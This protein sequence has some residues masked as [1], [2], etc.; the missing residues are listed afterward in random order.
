MARKQ[1][2]VGI[3]IGHSNIRIVQVEKT[4][5]G[6]RLTKF[7]ITETPADSVR[8]G[9]VRNPE[10]VG[11]AIKTAMKEAH[12]NAH[13]AVIAASGGAVYVRAVPF[14]KMNAAMLRES[15]KFEASRYVPGSIEDSYVEAEIL[16]NLNDAQMN[17]LLAAAPRDIVDGRIAACKAAGLDVRVVEIETFAASRALLETDQTKEMGTNTYILVDIGAASTTV[18]VIENGT[19]VMHRSMPTAGNTLTEGLKAAFKLETVDAEAGKH[20]LDLAEFLTPEGQENPPLKVIAAHVD[21]LVRE[22]RRSMNYLQTQSQGDLTTPTKI[23]GMFL[24]GAGANLKGRDKYIQSKLGIP[25][26]TIGVF[27]NPIVTQTGV[28]SDTGVDLAVATGLAMRP[29]LHAA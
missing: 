14:P 11:H 8:D 6:V 21:D 15:L 1:A 7:A 25:V 9:L 17:V 3:D 5:G 18:S 27:E 22:L 4:A 2:Y 24:C 26:K 28:F 20:A 23:D 13:R 16:E 12:M 19:Y 29:V 10:E